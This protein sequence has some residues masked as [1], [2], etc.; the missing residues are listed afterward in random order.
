MLLLAASTCRITLYKQPWFVYQLHFVPMISSSL[1]SSRWRQRLNTH[2]NNQGL[3]LSMNKCASKNVTL[4]C[5]WAKCPCL[6][7]TDTKYNRW[8]TA[9]WN[10]VLFSLIIS[11]VACKS[12]RAEMHFYKLIAWGR[13]TPNL[14]KES[15]I[16]V[17]GCTS[18]WRFSHFATWDRAMVHSKLWPYAENRVRSGVWKFCGWVLLQ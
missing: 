5:K 13:L 11:V 9:E 16:Q 6:N 15:L 7:L 18:V 12:S 10:Q 3:S 1:L 2:L 8:K 4:S 17:L 14:M